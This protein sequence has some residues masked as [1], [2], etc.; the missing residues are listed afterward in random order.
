MMSRLEKRYKEVIHGAIK[1]NLKLRND[2]SVPK[3]K[4]IVIN[5]TSKDIVQNSKVISQLFNDIYLISGQ[6]PVITKAKKSIAGFKIRKGMDIGVKVTLRRSRMY[7]FVDRLVNIALPRIRDFKGLDGRKFD[8]NGNY[9]FGV[10]EQIVFPEIDFGNI[11]K[12]R[13]LN[14]CIETT[15][16][17]NDHAKILLEQ[18]NFPFINYR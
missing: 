8:G 9:S 18:F 14:I 13:G 10:K 12:V 1:K 7:E 2:I 5:T 11:E 16:R 6:K 4:K 17:S 3:I 15:A